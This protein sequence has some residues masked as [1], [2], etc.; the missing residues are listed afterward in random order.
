MRRRR[1]HVNAFQQHRDKWLHALSELALLLMPPWRSPKSDPSSAAKPL[2]V[3]ASLNK[4]YPLC[5]LP[6]FIPILCIIPFGYWW[7]LVKGHANGG[8]LFTRVLL[9]HTYRF[10][11]VC[12][13]P[14]APPVPPFPL[15]PCLFLFHSS[16]R[17]VPGLHFRVSL[18]CVCPSGSSHSTAESSHLV[19]S[20]THIHLSSRAPAVDMRSPRELRR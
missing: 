7:F 8:P 15:L 20:A 2:G 4:G 6:L 3:D 11:S 5:I 10:A 17:Q 13:F 12:V 14:P 9:S 19:D 18:P 1:L 16:L